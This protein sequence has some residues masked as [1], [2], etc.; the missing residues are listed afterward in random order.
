MDKFKLSYVENA[1]AK[2]DWANPFKDYAKVVVT[3]KISLDDFD[4]KPFYRV[5]IKLAKKFSG[6]FDEGVVLEL[7]PNGSRLAF[8]TKLYKNDV[9]INAHVKYLDSDDFKDVDTLARLI[10]DKLDTIPIIITS[11]THLLKS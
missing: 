1:L 11:L 9:M 10:N 5:D 3:S 6:D 7:H 4:D 8:W 2:I